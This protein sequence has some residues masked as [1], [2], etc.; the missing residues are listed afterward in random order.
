LLPI[1]TLSV[2]PRISLAVN[3]M[4]WIG[5]RIAA[6]DAAAQLSLL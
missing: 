1:S 6:V 3:V 2:E 4:S 5:E